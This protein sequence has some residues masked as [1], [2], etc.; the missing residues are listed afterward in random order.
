MRFKIFIILTIF[1]SLFLF[2]PAQATDYGLSATMKATGGL[3]PDKIQGASTLPELGGVIVNVVLSLVGIL[4]FALM[5]Y[6]GI[7][8]MKAMGSS[9]DVTKAKDMITQAIIGLVVVM[10]AYAISNF[11]FTSLGATGGGSSTGGGS[12]TGASG[13]TGA[14]VVYKDGD[15]CTIHNEN[16]SD[17]TVALSDS[18]GQWNIKGP[19]CQPSCRYH[20]AG[21]KCQQGSCVGGSPIDPKYSTNLCPSGSNCCKP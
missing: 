20:N 15:T 16:W 10:A 8:W 13:G 6:A 17:G 3:L 14:S 21:A 2:C 9:E 19:E 12:G 7:I 11:V 1:F 4:F 5:L 18:S